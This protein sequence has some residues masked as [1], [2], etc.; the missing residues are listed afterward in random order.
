MA[1]RINK[2]FTSSAGNNNT[3]TAVITGSAGRRLR[4]YAIHAQKTSASG[5][6]KVAF[7]FSGE[8][9]A[10][11][12]R[13]LLDPNGNSVPVVKDMG[14]SYW[15]G[16]AGDSFQYQQV[17]GAAGGAGDIEISVDYDWE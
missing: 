5:A 4:I 11:L 1:R 16:V 15:L 2:T 6:S 12:V 13:S 9:S 17:D 8:N 14:E 3:R 7:W 10:R